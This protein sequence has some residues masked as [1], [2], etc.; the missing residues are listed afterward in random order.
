MLSHGIDS[1]SRQTFWTSSC[2][3]LNDFEFFTGRSGV[4]ARFAAAVAMVGS[5]FVASASAHEGHGSPPAA[6]KPAARQSSSGLRQQSP[7]DEYVDQKPMPAPHGGQITPTRS[8]HFEVVYT[9]QETRL[10]VY[11]PSRQ[12]VNVRGIT[13][14]VEMEMNADRKAFRFPLQVVAGSAYSADVGYLVAGV[15]VSRVRDGDMQ[16][17]FLLNNL[18]ARDEPQARFTQTFALS[19]PALSVNVVPLTEADRPLIERQR[20]CPVMDAGLRDHGTPIKLLVNNQP[21][22]LC[23]EGCIEEV[24]KNPQHYVNKL[25]QLAAAESVTPPAI[26]INYAKESD[27]PAAMRQGR[28][29]LSGQP[30]GG[31]AAPLKI[32]AEGRELFVCCATCARELE[33]NPSELVRLINVQQ[34]PPTISQTSGSS[35]INSQAAGSQ[36][37]YRDVSR[38]QTGNSAASCSSGHCGKCK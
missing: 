32:V 12:P 28:C 3:S 27:R 38:L 23:C 4:T 10:Y 25:A 1:C 13:G 5:L 11:S 7:R 26:L 24:Q 9:P 29:P 36:Q 18:P 19:R 2:R 30:F 20:I 8:H 31:P 22:Y 33:Q 16:A 17:T 6:T 37:T 21:L 15:D 34:A 35:D 14:E